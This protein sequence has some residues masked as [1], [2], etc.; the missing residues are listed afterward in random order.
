MTV[1]VGENGSGKSTLVEAVARAWQRSLTAAVRHWAPLPSPD[2]FPLW[3]ELDL[4]GE[5]PRPQ[6]GAFLRAEA[7]HGHFSSLDE[8]P[9]GVRAFGGPL[10]ARSH[11]EGFLAFL[12]ERTSERGLWVLDDRRTPCPPPLARS[13]RDPAG[14]VVAAGSQVLLATHSPLLAALPG[15]LVYQLDAGGCAVREWADLELVRDWRL[16][17]DDPRRLLHH[18]LVE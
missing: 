9:D 2:E 7:T 5:H 13:R 14:G 3:D 12:E 16:F 4:H 11:A 18:L 17:L 6:G 10:H 8:G 1:L 15:A